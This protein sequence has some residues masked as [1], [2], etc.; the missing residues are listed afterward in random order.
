MSNPV[1]K[2]D[3]REVQVTPDTA[4]D[5]VGR[6]LAELVEGVLP[7]P[8]TE[9]RMSAAVVVTDVSKPV[10]DVPAVVTAASGPVLEDEIEGDAPPAGRRGRRAK[11]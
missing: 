6:G 8:S 3:G 2:Y 5:L 1:I 9:R 10:K 11:G 7:D 4:A